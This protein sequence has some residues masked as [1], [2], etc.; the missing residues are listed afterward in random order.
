MAQENPSSSEEPKKS[1]LKLLL[2]SEP[3]NDVE[4]S[5]SRICVYP[6]RVRDMT[7]FGKFDPGEA[8][9]SDQGFPAEH[10]QFECD[11]AP[12]RVPFDAA[13]LGSLYGP[14]QRWL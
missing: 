11:D 13:E 5:V 7:A 2:W 12:E 3:I 6:L 8:G 4:T 9:Q 10:W 1:T 14:E